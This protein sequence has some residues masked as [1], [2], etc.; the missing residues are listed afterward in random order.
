MAKNNSHNIG[1]SV[2][3]LV[4]ALVTMVAFFSWAPWLAAMSREEAIERYG[5]PV[6]A[7]WEAVVMGHGQLSEFTW[8]TVS[9]NPWGFALCTG[10]VFG[11]AIFIIATAWWS[12]RKKKSPRNET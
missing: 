11:G 8:G 7:E 6:P 5:L 1:L 3:Q 10:L 2:A 9:S 4:V 12:S